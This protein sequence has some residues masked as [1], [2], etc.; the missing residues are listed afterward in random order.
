MFNAD[1]TGALFDPTIRGRLT[2]ATVEI[3]HDPPRG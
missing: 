2:S 1:N 3:N